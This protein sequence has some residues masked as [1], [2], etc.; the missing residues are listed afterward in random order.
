MSTYDDADG[1]VASYPGVY[2]ATYDW[3]VS[4]A[5]TGRALI[6][7]PATIG[8]T[9][10]S[11]LNNPYI[12]IFSLLIGGGMFLAQNF[13]H[14]AQQEL[15]YGV[16]CVVRPIYQD[17]VRKV[18]ELLQRIYNPVICWWNGVNWI[19]F[20]TWRQ[21]VYP[22]AQK[23]N[24]SGIFINVANLVQV[25]A[26]QF[27]ADFIATGDFLTLAN[28]IYDWGPGSDP[29]NQPNGQTG[30]GTGTL[31]QTWQTL[32][33]SWL[34]LLCC[35]CQDLCK[36]LKL[37]PLLILF[38][39]PPIPPIG[40][41]GF[42]FISPWLPGL[43]AS[44][45]IGDEQLWRGVFHLVNAALNIL[46]QLWAIILWVIIYLI[47]LTPNPPPFPRPDFRV[48]V[49]LVC[50]SA[51]GLVRSCEN[52]AQLFVECFLPFP[53][54]FRLFFCFVDTA[55][56]ILLKLAATIL[57]ILVNADR[58]GAPENLWQTRIRDEFIE[59]F[60]RIAPV[61][62]PGFSLP[63][64]PGQGG[65][66][67]GVPRLSECVC[68]FLQRLLCDPQLKCYDENLN[69][70]PCTCYGQALP[71]G[72]LNEF[73]LCCIVERALT[74]IN[75]VFFALLDISYHVDDVVT[76]VIWLDNDF[77]RYVD[78]VV[79][80]DFVGETSFTNLMGESGGLLRCFGSVYR[81]IPVVGS[82]IES[83]RIDFLARTF[84]ALNVFVIKFLISALVSTLV[85][86]LGTCVQ[87]NVGPEINCAVPC[88]GGAGQV[89]T[90]AAPCYPAGWLLTRGRARADWERI[91][92]PIIIKDTNTPAQNLRSAENCIC[93]ILNLIPIPR[94][95]CTNCFT[96]GFIPTVDL[97][98]GE[99]GAGEYIECTKSP[100]E[101]I[102]RT[103]ADGLGGPLPGEGIVRDAATSG[104][105]EGEIPERYRKSK[106]GDSGKLARRFHT[107]M[108]A[109]HDAYSQGGS[110]ALSKSR[111]RVDELRASLRSARRNTEH[112]K[113][114][115]GLFQGINAFVRDQTRRGIKGAGKLRS[116]ADIEGFMHDKKR[117]MMDTFHKNLDQ[118]SPLEEPLR[119]WTKQYMRDASD[120][121]ADLLR[122][123][124]EGVTSV[125]R[126][127]TDAKDRKLIHGRM[128]GK[129]PETGEY[130]VV[131]E[132]VECLPTPGCFDICCI[133][134]RTLRAAVRLLIQVGDFFDA[135][136]FGN[137]EMPRWQY[138]VGPESDLFLA[139]FEIDL[140]GLLVEIVEI[141][142]CAC[143]II[144]LLFPIP[145]L[146]LCC[147]LIAAADLGAEILI[148]I[149]KSIKSLALDNRCLNPRSVQ[150]GTNPF[151]GKPVFELRGDI[152]VGAA[153]VL[154][155]NAQCCP[156]VDQIGSNGA[157]TVATTA[158][159]VCRPD[160]DN[161]SY[162]TKAFDAVSGYPGGDGPATAACNPGDSVA[163]CDCCFPGQSQFECDIDRMAD[164]TI[165]IVVCLCDIVRAV[166]PIPGLDLC[167][168]A[169][170]VLV[171]AIEIIRLFIEIVVNLGTINTVGA[172]YF[173]VAPPTMPGGLPGPIDDIGLVRQFDIIFDSLFGMPGG[174]CSFQ[175]PAS[176]PPHFV[177]GEAVGGAF[178]C[179][180]QIL[181]WIVPARQYP[182]LAVGVCPPDD[183]NCN[184]CPLI[185]LCCLF[186]ETGFLLNA[187]GQFLIRFI[188]T[189]WQDWY[190]DP[191]T[192]DPNPAPVVAIKFLFCDELGEW[193]GSNQYP[194]SD[195]IWPQPGGG[196]G[197]SV[198]VTPSCG[199]IQPILDAI[200]NII[201]DCPCA[202]MQFVDD[203]LELIFPGDNQCFCGET[204]G[205]FKVLPRLVKVILQ[206]VIQFLRMFWSADFWSS[207]DGPPD[208]DNADLMGSFVPPLLP[209]GSLAPFNPLLYRNQTW[210]RWFFLP[211]FDLL[212]TTVLSFLCI[213]DVIL[214]ALFGCS[215]LRRKLV[216]ALIVWPLEAIVVLAE[217]VEGIANTFSGNCGYPEF[218]QVQPDGTQVVI[219]P[220]G[221]GPGGM[222]GG[223]SSACIGGA[224]VGIFQFPIDLLIADGELKT[225][226]EQ[227]IP[228]AS[229]NEALGNDQLDQLLADI[230][231][232]GNLGRVSGIFIGFVRY[233]A[234]LFTRLL[235]INDPGAVDAFFGFATFLSILWQLSVK[236]LASLGAFINLMIAIIGFTAG[237][238]C[239]CHR[240]FPAVPNANNPTGKY[241]QRGGLCYY[242]KMDPIVDDGTLSGNPPD[243]YFDAYNV[244][245][246]GVNYV[247]PGP[248][249]CPDPY[250]FSPA[251]SCGGRGTWEETFPGSG[252]YEPARV[253][254]PG[255][256][257]ACETNFPEEPKVLCSFIQVIES[258]F[259]FI[260]SVFDI[261]NPP[262]VVPPTPPTNRRRNAA[263]Q[264]AD[265]HR[266][267]DVDEEEEEEGKTAFRRPPVKPHSYATEFDRRWAK[268][269]SEQSHPKLSRQMADT[270]EFLRRAHVTRDQ[271]PSWY[272]TAST[273]DMFMESVG[274]FNT[275]D[276]EV[277]PIT[278]LCR[279]VPHLMES[280][281][282]YNPETGE[283]TSAKPDKSPVTEND[284]LHALGA[285]CSGGTT[286]CDR[287][288]SSCA[289]DGWQSL[290]SSNAML[291]LWAEC[292]EK[293]VTGERINAVDSRFPADF[294]HDIPT[295]FS[296]FVHNLMQSAN[297]T[298]AQMRRRWLE[299]TDEHL[300]KQRRAHPRGLSEREQ[301]REYLEYAFRDS[302]GRYQIENP[303]ILRVWLK[304][305]L[306]WRKISSGMLGHQ[307][308]RAAH[309]IRRGTWRIPVYPAFLD[310]SHK[311]KDLGNFIVYDTHWRDGIARTI[312]HSLRAATAINDGVRNTVS[313]A[314]THG[315]FSGEHSVY[316]TFR[317]DLET[318]A[319]VLREEEGWGEPPV[320]GEYRKRLV[321]AFYDGPAYKWWHESWKRQENPLMPFVDHIKRVWR[322][323]KHT[324]FWK[325]RQ[326][327]PAAETTP[328][329]LWERTPSQWDEA[330]KRWAKRWE[331]RWDWRLPDWPAE[332]ETEDRWGNL[333]S[334]AGTAIT[335][336]E[337]VYPGSVDEE[338]RK[339]WVIGPGSDC[340]LIANTVA[341]VVDTFSYCATEY[342]FNLPPPECIGA[343]P[344]I[345]CARRRR[346]EMLAAHEAGKPH[347][348]MMPQGDSALQRWLR[349]SATRRRSGFLRH[350]GVQWNTA[351]GNHS[352]ISWRKWAE[353]D[354]HSYYRPRVIHDTEAIHDKRTWGRIHPHHW[355]RV[356]SF[357]TSGANFYTTFFCWLEDLLGLSV[358]PD[359]AQFFQDFIDWVTNPNL[360][361]EDCG[362]PGLLG[363]GLQYW[364]LFWIRCEWPEYVNCSNACALGLKEALRRVLI[365]SAIVFGGLTIF[366]PSLLLPI[367]STGGLFFYLIV[368]PAAA[369]HYSPQ[370][371]FIF[372]SI[373]IPGI[374]ISVPVLPFPIGLPVLPECL[375]D[376]IKAL[377]DDLLSPCPFVD[378]LSGIFPLCLYNGNPCPSCPDRVSMAN[379]VNVGV[380]DGFSNLAY[381]LYWVA[382]GAADYISYTLSETCFFS[383]CLIDIPPFNLE[384]LVNKFEEFRTASDTQQCRQQWCFWAMILSILLPAALIA[385]VG[386]VA[387]VII[388]W[389]L[390]VLFSLFWLVRGSPIGMFFP[391]SESR[392]VD[393]GTSPE[394]DYATATEPGS[395]YVNDA[396]PIAGPF[397]TYRR[398]QF[399]EDKRQRLRREATER[400]MQ[401][402]EDMKAQRSASYFLHE[403]MRPAFDAFVGWFG[404]RKQ[405]RD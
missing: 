116:P 57:H 23:C 240:K 50:L 131:D 192:A 152:C 137:D 162:F 309:N 83:L 51:A 239:Q 202:V 270:R 118:Q 185:D 100:Y 86:E 294:F 107:R 215:V 108:G 93:A 117:A 316:Q 60:N 310:F 379:C 271:D 8:S 181:N 289:D 351:A 158:P 251:G 48:F 374:G 269:L 29:F 284:V 203:L 404:P 155:V 297:R 16:R 37:Q 330:K 11:L 103:C 151:N 10:L 109:M 127:D 355:K 333:R 74:I 164:Q 220:G 278:C 298:G 206:R 237:D 339:R 12:I 373:P 264:T 52:A 247:N 335:S 95:P 225:Q 145:F 245:M 156:S 292:V 228:P 359:I 66:L 263:E 166:F 372:P 71:T 399:E 318:R 375:L 147:P 172:D 41:P 124:P 150:T 390:D 42:F 76:F 391:G 82:C 376:D 69:Q 5:Y 128:H 101:S 89:P 244:F 163:Q 6:A 356:T 344:N 243:T 149:V 112:G 384:Y 43:V 40:F 125:R 15:E 55:I 7:G 84:L 324:P 170:A 173:K 386:I 65:P 36:F 46:Q 63:N 295:G 139:D 257:L 49:Q 175:E 136:F 183:P 102:D 322:V 370:C 35:L 242:C 134:K 246:N 255:A 361:P 302:M 106:G 19:T 38:G 321:D 31:C 276:C 85:L 204:R 332:K 81:R 168:A 140:I 201:S 209:D 314:L 213:P 44:Q 96:C 389:L 354:E 260:G 348:L 258:F 126:F 70:V 33:T 345:G 79:L 176:S 138:F 352:R 342:T 211:I 337:I 268:R 279:N 80:D 231:T 72:I 311:M 113:S 110:K 224:I 346:E 143:N 307:M 184:N 121:E 30:A 267:E 188:A 349:N 272:N 45:Q 253:E 363:V 291:F 1:A 148:T 398:T 194:S 54:D 157:C 122:Y 252:V 285:A 90:L 120:P 229:P 22:L 315:V 388:V 104:E 397:I 53:F 142:Q 377:L 306:K 238:L 114:P 25:V 249:G 232:C 179:V 262:P 193:A 275:D 381:L 304:I 32:W 369:W 382:P 214:G 283:V 396:V 91:W 119:S 198:L 358:S 195:T 216:A 364:L 132:R 325:L 393:P 230:P 360:N 180:C 290:S 282:T 88:D 308:R 161:F 182:S 123:A 288:I 186:R 226:A 305:D 97:G 235:G 208:T 210:A 190:D 334:I 200:E 75:D 248:L 191:A 73:S 353:G 28:G 221:G 141:V 385:F 178:T 4:V 234:C 68:I 250:Y 169:E 34:D 280:V 401:L 165:I 171:T 197:P 105:E 227:G 154:D 300:Q 296:N 319:R 64:A 402:R 212:C 405:K 366:I 146:D 14:T 347:E 378:N 265:P 328:S 323:Y 362:K 277:D 18:L 99:T 313:R 187:I 61:N 340:D 3:S 58:L 331:P 236:L 387:A 233:L 357:I 403:T 293:Y 207:P 400:R 59:V 24:I 301:E 2:T 87:A 133:F 218:T 371:W 256:P 343:G 78:I 62:I 77:L 219:P 26:T 177:G 341:L 217:L 392:W 205:L 273:M 189:L 367:I 286:H 350:R 47:F 320:R 383:G 98:N 130:R 274:G 196:K 21:V 317:G 368:V 281:C 135:L 259:Q 241:Q 327:N 312:E 167:C 111:K 254:V 395:S 56:C 394:F 266:G 39:V 129:D 336:Y 67:E 27:V 153:E 20:G 94:L 326:N 174:R 160:S 17:P 338:T 222:L 92:D 299:E 287:L 329:R 9:I 13:H 261:F 159:F 380:A 115:Y 199:K 303:E 144:E 223:V 365:I